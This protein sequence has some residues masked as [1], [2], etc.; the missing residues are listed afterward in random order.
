MNV[1]RLKLDEAAIA[2]LAE[3]IE[4]LVVQHVQEGT[5]TYTNAYFAIAVVAGRLIAT[6][7]EDLRNRLA[8]DL[9]ECALKSAVV[10]LE[11]EGQAGRNETKH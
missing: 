5:G 6:L 4:D 1:I 2:D 7:P 9:A 8:A 3:K 11:V 10:R